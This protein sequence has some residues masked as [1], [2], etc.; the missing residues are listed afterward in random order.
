MTAHP[1]VDAPRVAIGARWWSEVT[2]MLNGPKHR[3]YIMLFML[4]VMAHWIEHIFQGAQ[5][6][7]LGWSRADARGAL[8][9]I[10]PTLVTSEG[11]HYGYAVIM[12][13]GI[14]L[15]RPG[16]TGRARTWWTAALVIQI[17]HHFEH[18]LL[19]G[20]AL[21]HSTLLGAAQPTS[22]IQ[23]IAPRIELHLFYN[24]IVF[25]PMVAAIYVQYLLRPR[26]SA[27]AV[28]G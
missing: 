23:L 3:K 26:P 9:E 16:F 28:R 6:W 27:R 14:I 8:G 1:N 19:L 7:L 22:I 21:T 20:Q 12:L 13:V 11:L 17:W 25:A 15:L 24:A 5:V 18:L 2:A 4:V 10:F